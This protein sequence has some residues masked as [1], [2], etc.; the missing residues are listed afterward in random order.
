MELPC[1]RRECDWSL[2]HRAPGGSVVACDRR[3]TG[4]QNICSNA[5]SETSRVTAKGLQ[6]KKADNG[7]N[8]SGGLEPFVLAGSPLPP[9]FAS[10][11][12]R[13]GCECWRRTPGTVNE[14]VGC[15][16]KAPLASFCPGSPLHRD[17]HASRCRIKIAVR[18]S[19]T[20]P[21]LPSRH[22]SFVSACGVFQSPRK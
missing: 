20:F 6:R 13:W 4:T 18:R 11:P 14:R 10:V 22:T 12:P 3:Q 5:K 2:S 16:D 1:H 19:G 7:S 8:T 17:A 15:R 21:D 9:T